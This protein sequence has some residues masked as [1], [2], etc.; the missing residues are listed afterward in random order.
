MKNCVLYLFSDNNRYGAHGYMFDN[1]PGAR[2]AKV[3]HLIT[4]VGYGK[5]LTGVQIKDAKYNPTWKYDDGVCEAK[6]KVIKPEDSD[7]TYI[8]FWNHDGT[9]EELVKDIEKIGATNMT[10]YLVEGWNLLGQS[11]HKPNV[12]N[13][14]VTPADCKF[15]DKGKL[16]G[17]DREYGA[18]ALRNFHFFGRGYKLKDQST[19]DYWESEKDFPPL[20]AH[21][22]SYTLTSEIGRTFA[23]SNGNTYHEYFIG[24]HA[25]SNDELEVLGKED[26]TTGFALVWLKEPCTILDEIAGAHAEKLW[27]NR[28]RFEKF[29]VVGMVSL[30]NI[31]RPKTR[32]DI[33]NFGIDVFPYGDYNTRMLS[34][35]ED[36]ISMCIVPPK[37]SY[38]ALGIRDEMRRILDSYFG[39]SYYPNLML[40]DITHLIY[41]DGKMTKF[42]G[43]T[44]DMFEY[45]PANHCNDMRKVQ[46]I[47]G[48]DFP[49]RSAFSGIVDTVKSVKLVTWPFSK[50][51][52]R[53]GMIIETEDSVGFWSA[54]YSGM[55]FCF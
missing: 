29:D 3:P 6:Y 46:F 41:E 48:I 5:K 7:I 43:M 17:E 40:T 26:P 50:K 21:K 18:Y 24:D 38:R 27:E 34:G 22:W 55:M 35:A 4:P 15:D 52:Y 12:A 25:K 19:N 1:L 9:A 42:I 16:K 14:K 36:L 33:R 51:V 30:N 10:I 23:A 28:R 39:A 20:L 13:L 44:T 47:R 45:C 32:F 31:T 37:I 54:G 11:E 49:I 2:Y 53:Y 8:D